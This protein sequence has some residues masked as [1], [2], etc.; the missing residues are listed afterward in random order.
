M[1]SR[2]GPVAAF[3][4][5]ALALL[6]EGA[7]AEM[8][9]TAAM[10]R[11]LEAGFVAAAFLALLVSLV[12]S[13]RT[14]TAVVPERESAPEARGPSSDEAMRESD[15]RRLRLF[16]ALPVGLLSLRPDGAIDVAN[17]R[18]HVLS[19]RGPDTL[20]GLPID[21]LADFPRDLRTRLAALAAAGRDAASLVPAFEEEIALVAANGETRRLWLSAWSRP[22]GGADVMLADA[23]SRRRLSEEV[24]YSRR[25]ALA[26]Q[27]ATALRLAENERPRVLL[28]EDHDENRELLAH[29]LSLKGAEVVAAGSGEEALAIASREAFSLVF[30]DVQMPEMD[31]WEVARRLR[32]TARG[33]ALPIVG[34][35]ALTSDAVRSRCLAEGM[36]EVV[37]KPV[38]KAQLADVLE[39]YTGY[40][41]PA[42]GAYVPVAVA[43][44]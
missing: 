21:Q 18:L 8:L 15:E 6:T 33:A 34:L 14:G 24:E 19:G 1:I 35:T 22:G 5:L 31:G 25:M 28:V 32:G 3:A 2:T 29:L 9:V 37:T 20:E 40:R 41:G 26:A 4:F 16:E 17:G 7:R 44:G 27:E 10:A 11:T 39:R 36:N 43:A 23:T 42:S 12:Q 13:R 30:L 38:T